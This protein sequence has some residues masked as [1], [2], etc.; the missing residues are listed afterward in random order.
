M[1]PESSFDLLLNYDEVMLNVNTYSSFILNNEIQKLEAEKE[2]AKAKSSVGLQA[3]INAQFGLTQ[4][5]GKLK[6]AY[7]NP[8]DQ[9][10]VGLS[11]KLPI[12]DWG[13]GKGRVKIAKSKDKVTDIQ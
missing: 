3:E 5:G 10:V 6:E 8:L 11:L 2:V 13:L 1:Q 9:E 12:M 7:Q 4:I